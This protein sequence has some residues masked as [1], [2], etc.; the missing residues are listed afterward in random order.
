M[1][2][3]FFQNND[4]SKKKPSIAKEYGAFLNL[5]WQIVITIGLMALLGDWLDKE[6]ETSPLWIIICSFFGVVVAMYSFIK[7]VINLTKKDK[8]K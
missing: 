6:F 7:T 8:K 4:N 1:S 5:G 2:Y 3:S